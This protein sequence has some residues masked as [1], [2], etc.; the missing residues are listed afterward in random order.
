MNTRIQVEHPVTE[1]ITGFDLVREQIRIADGRGLSVAQEDLEFRGHAIECR[2]NAEDP[3]SFMPSPGKVTAYHPAGGIHVRVHTG[4]YAGSSTPPYSHSM[5]GKLTV[6][7]RTSA[8]R[9]LRRR[10]PAVEMDQRK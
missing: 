5:I 6:H 10:R 7:G 3:R 8:R 1:M 4:L 9:Q 2:N